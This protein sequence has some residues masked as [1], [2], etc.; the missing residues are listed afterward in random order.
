MYFYILS[1]I[2][3]MKNEFIF[4]SYDMVSEFEYKSDYK[5]LKMKYLQDFIEGEDFI[6]KQIKKD[7][8]GRGKF[9]SDYVLNY[10]SYNMVLERMKT[11]FSIYAYV[12]PI[13]GEIKYIG[14]SLNE[15]LRLK[16]AYSE[17][18]NPAKIEWLHN[19][20]AKNLKPILRVL[21]VASTESEAQEKEQEYI[22]NHIGSLFNGKNTHP[23]TAKK[24]KYKTY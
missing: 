4:S 24:R 16:T 9:I 23:Y 7:P 8:L 10:N 13:E 6:I 12:C 14:C 18:V 19:L 3:I 21:A 1:Y 5:Y 22:N 20:R 15:F 2:R 11:P 17:K